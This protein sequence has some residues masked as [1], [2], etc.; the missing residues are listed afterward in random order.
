M[1]T[2]GTMFV[3]LYRHTERERFKI[4]TFGFQYGNVQCFSIYMSKSHDR[5]ITCHFTVSRAVKEVNS[6]NVRLYAECQCY[7]PYFSWLLQGKWL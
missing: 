5:L 6:M 3:Y 2:I 7:V 4:N 1:N